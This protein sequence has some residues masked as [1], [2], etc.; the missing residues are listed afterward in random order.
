MFEIKDGKLV[1]LGGDK[2]QH[3]AGWLSTTISAN[4][5][6]IVTASNDGTSKVFEIKDGKLVELG[7]DKIKQEGLLSSKISPNEKYRV[8]PAFDGTSQVFE[9]VKDGEKTKL[10]ELGKD[11]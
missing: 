10:V 9:I 11:K 2:I 3:T 6:Y 4:D 1:E 5:K 7:G 8:T